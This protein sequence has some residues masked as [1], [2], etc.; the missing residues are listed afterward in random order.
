[1][2]DLMP[3]SAPAATTR[4][5]KD[6]DGGGSLPP[7][8]IRYYRQMKPQ[9][10]ASAEVSWKKSKKSRNG[11]VT[12]RLLGAGAQI[13]PAE[14]T[15]NSA[16]QDK[17]A[18]FYL[19]PLAQGWLPNLQLEVLYQ[20]RKVQEI[21]LAGKVVGQ[22]F[23]WFLLLCTFLVPWFISEFIKFSPMNMTTVSPSHQV[24]HRYPAKEVEA[25]IDDNMPVI[26]G[27]LKGT[28]VDSGMTWIRSS[29]ATAYQKLVQVAYVQPL[30]FF[31]ACILLVL[32]AV[33]AYL[34][35]T[36]RC[37]VMGKPIALPASL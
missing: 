33:S 32:T 26:P 1:M 17:K 24:I 12:V 18:I 9:R 29:V 3:E 21:A 13:L 25:Y 35:K 7:L 14:Q 5:A 11:E 19:T 30:S 27:F 37:T 20:G 22:R 23:T 16:E 15:L 31:A 4:S 36:K 34:H 28:V 10:V 2:G 8:R 6:M